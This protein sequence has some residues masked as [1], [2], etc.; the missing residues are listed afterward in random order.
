MSEIREINA[1]AIYR[2]FKNKLY[3]TVGFSFP[4]DDEDVEFFKS[5]G[6]DRLSF[7]HTEEECYIPCFVNE[8]STTDN[9][10][11]FFHKRDYHDGI[12]VVYT[13][14]T[15]PVGH[16]YARPVEMF[17]SEVDKKKYP[18]VEQ[19]YRFER[20]YDDVHMMSLLVGMEE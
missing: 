13:G 17:A 18:N 4:C 9:C 2:H 1:P 12:L 10:S 20:V 15:E 8:F 7:W 3:A 19:Q 11:D 14:V 5:E 6:Y 16:Y